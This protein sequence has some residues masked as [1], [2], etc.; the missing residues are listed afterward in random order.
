MYQ[1]MVGALQL[2]V[3]IGCLDVTTAVMTM[4]GFRIAPRVGHLDRSMQIYGYLCKMRHACYI[5]RTDDPDYSNLPKLSQ[6]WSRSVYEEII[7]LIPHEAA[8]LLGKNVTLTR[9]VDA[10]L[11]HDVVTGISVTGTIHLLVL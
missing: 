2:V 4:S 7:K 1:S 5:I 10:N 9:Y 6:Y 8:E 3:T 11:M